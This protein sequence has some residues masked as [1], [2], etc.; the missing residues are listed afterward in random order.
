[1]LARV[2]A[3]EKPATLKQAPGRDLIEANCGACHSL[4]YIPMNSLFLNAEQWKAE[5]AKMINAFGAPIS[6]A[7]AKTI[8]DY[9]VA[10][11]GEGSAPGQ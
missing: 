7:D 10:N 11:Y 9:L 6:E 2:A 8:V 3:E 1:M 5:V 4:D